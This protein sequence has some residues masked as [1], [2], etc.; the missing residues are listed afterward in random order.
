MLGIDNDPINNQVVA[1]PRIDHVTARR[2]IDRVVAT[3]HEQEIV[4]LSVVKCLVFADANINIDMG[5]ITLVGSDFVG[6]L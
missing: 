5:I 3:L 1:L 2:C 4:S 6:S